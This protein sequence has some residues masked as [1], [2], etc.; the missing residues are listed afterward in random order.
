MATPRFR[1]LRKLFKALGH[2]MES[3]HPAEMAEK[4]LGSAPLV[5]P[6]VEQPVVAPALD[7]KVVLSKV[8]VKAL[9]RLAEGDEDLADNFSRAELEEI[10]DHFGIEDPGSLPNKGAISGAIVEAHQG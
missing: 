8:V 10:A 1:R 3:G 7:E 2:K 5:T 4:A 9:S 6:A